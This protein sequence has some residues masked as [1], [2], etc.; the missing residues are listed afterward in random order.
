MT[1]RTELAYRSNG[2]LDVTLLWVHGDAK[3]TA[4]VCVCDKREGAYMEITAGPYLALNV[5]YH[6]FAYKDFATI[7][8]EDSRLAA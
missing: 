8:Y 7:E 1:T 2:G 4:V 6:P 5:Y 3:D